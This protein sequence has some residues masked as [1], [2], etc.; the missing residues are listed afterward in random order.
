MSG[1]TAWTRRATDDDLV[2][3]I[4]QRSALRWY[5]VESP[6]CCDFVDAGRAREFIPAAWLV[7]AF[8]PSQELAARRTGFDSPQPWLVRVIAQAAP[9]G[10]DW[11]DHALKDGS[12]QKLVLF[13]EWNGDGSYKEG[14]QFRDLFWYPNVNG[15]QDSRVCLVAQCQAAADGPPIVRWVKLVP[16][17]E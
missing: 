11:K 5:F 15:S 12:E 4:S 1:W 14:R 10:N 13:G 6:T 8:E 9:E 17:T 7:R 2:K 3:L 16:L